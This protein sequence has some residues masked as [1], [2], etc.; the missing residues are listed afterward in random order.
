MRGSRGVGEWFKGCGWELTHRSMDEGFQ[1]RGWA[2]QG[3]WVRGSRGV[4]KGFQRCGWGVTG[5]WVRG[6]WGVGEGFQGHG[7][8]VLGAW[9]RLVGR[10]LPS[11]ATESTRQA[12]SHILFLRWGSQFKGDPCQQWVSAKLS[13]S[14]QGSLP[15]SQH[16][17]QRTSLF[18]LYRTDFAQKRH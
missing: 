14:F 12:P 2:I 17:W 13:S 11:L 9:V 3:A 16:N 6:Y 4:D 1:G 7:W 8:G 5:A 15:L 18:L 10:G